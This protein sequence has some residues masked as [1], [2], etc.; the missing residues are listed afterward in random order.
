MLYDKST[1]QK[2]FSVQNSDCVSSS[3]PAP[4]LQLST[5]R[6]PPT[7]HPAPPSLLLTFNFP[8]LTSHFQL[9][10]LPR[11]SMTTQDHFAKAGGRWA[12][13]EENIEIFPCRWMALPILGTHNRQLPMCTYSALIIV[14]ISHNLGHY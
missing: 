9:I 11:S 7:S 5:S 6:S 13:G 10:Q 12:R 1:S 4:N 8:L 14:R 2:N 3:L